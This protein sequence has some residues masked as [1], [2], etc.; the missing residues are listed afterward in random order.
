MREAVIAYW[1]GRSRCPRP[2]KTT[3]ATRVPPARPFR[4]RAGDDGVP[5]VLCRGKM[6]LRRRSR[7]SPRICRCS[8]R[9]DR[10]NRSRGFAG[11]RTNLRPGA[12]DDCRRWWAFMPAADWRHPVGPDSTIEALPDHPVVHI[13]YAGRCRLGGQGTFDQ[14]N[15]SQKAVAA[16]RCRITAAAA[17]F[18][19]PA[20]AWV[21][22]RRAAVGDRPIPRADA[23]PAHLSVDASVRKPPAARGAAR[24]LARPNSLP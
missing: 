22:G 8:P 11:L 17:C 2:F 14:P 20:R 18:P 13:A 19:A 21:P 10:G 6:P 1:F 16:C 7:Q 5:P 12:L 15:N 3:G 9:P 23:P 4:E 24:R